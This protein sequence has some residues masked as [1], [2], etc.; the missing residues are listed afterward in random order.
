[1]PPALGKHLGGFDFFHALVGQ[2][3]RHRRGACHTRTAQ[4][5]W[6]HP[7]DGS[8]LE[9]AM[10]KVLWQLVEYVCVCVPC[11]ITHNMSHAPVI[12]NDMLNISSFMHLC[13]KKAEEG[14]RSADRR[15]NATKSN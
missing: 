8:Q 6:S 4:Y 14:A 13:S 1:M 11:A 2:P 12:M 9:H 10:K 5:T 15:K 7:P 3:Q